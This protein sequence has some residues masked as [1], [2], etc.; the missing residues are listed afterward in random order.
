ML[1]VGAALPISATW[2]CEQRLGPALARRRRA[3]TAARGGQQRAAAAARP[4]FWE[5]R[6]SPELLVCCMA[7]TMVGCALAA[8]LLVKGGGPLE[9][10][11]GLLLPSSG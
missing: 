8:R 1:F 5:L 2:P 4:P 9:R 3:R 11:C 6:G 7:A 10:D